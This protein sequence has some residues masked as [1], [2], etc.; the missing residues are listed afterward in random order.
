ML[1]GLKVA[2]F[3]FSE[4]YGE[5][6]AGFTHSYNITKNL[7]F[8]CEKINVFFS[9]SEVKLIEEIE[10]VQYFGVVIPT[11]KKIV[12][13]KFLKSYFFIKEK[14]KDADLIHERF[15]VNPIDL[16]FISKKK[17]YVLEI[18]D[19]AMVLHESSLY[20]FLI[21]LK[22]KRADVIITQT[23]TLKNIL[24]QYTTKPIFVVSNGVDTKF[25]SKQPIFNV[26]EQYGI[27]D[28]EILVVFVGAFMQW[29]GVLDVVKLAKIFKNIKFLMVGNGPEFEFVQ[30]RSQGL[31]NLILTGSK[32]KDEI[33]SYL[34]AADITIAPFNTSK[35]KKLDK[36]G[37]WWCPVK[38]FEYI[39]A[40][41]PVLS[42]NYDEVSNIVQDAGLLAKPGDFK[43]LV[44]KLRKLISDY[45]LKLKLSNNAKQLAPKYDWKY[46]SEETY[47][48]YK[49]VLKS[50]SAIR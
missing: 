36:Y 47:Q 24:S 26:R 35:F 17:P 6:H 37:F 25:F 41:K 29:H 21:N 2:Y 20:Q 5:N 15:H 38:L 46:R 8:L 44:A 31:R 30:K 23:N 40:G 27:K 22:L 11:L 9:D 34:N 16:L 42:Y 7:K 39:A 4:H 43:D 28:N 50:K 32:D 19:P 48:I 49:E 33:P 12:N 1:N 13:F 18:N 3:A 45:E 10:N 14:I